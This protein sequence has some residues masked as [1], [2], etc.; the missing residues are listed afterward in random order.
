MINI[1]S[2]RHTENKMFRSILILTEKE[3]KT[4]NVQM[5]DYINIQAYYQNK[6]KS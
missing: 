5:I 1:H 2:H 6:F 3:F 4:D